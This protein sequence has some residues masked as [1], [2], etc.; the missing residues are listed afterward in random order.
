MIHNGYHTKGWARL[1]A[2][3]LAAGLLCACS[4]RPSSSQAPATVP[5]AAVQPTQVA[6]TEPETVADMV[7]MNGGANFLP[8][9]SLRLM[10]DTA[11]V[12]LTIAQTFHITRPEQALTTS[13]D[14]YFITGTS[15]P[16]KP[17]YFGTEEIV[18]QGT[19]GTFGV[20]VPLEMGENS[21]RFSQGGQ[22]TVV[23]ITRKSSTVSAIQVVQQDSMFPASQGG[24]KV[25][26]TLPVR[27]IAPAG[28]AVT[29]SFGGKTVT[30][31]QVAQANPGIP[32]VF[33]ADLTVSGDYPAGVTQKVG[34]VTYTLQYGG[35]T[36]TYK[37]TGDVYVAGANSSLAVRVKNYAGFVY[38]DLK[39][40]SNMKE[41][42]KKGAV[43][44]AA[45]EDSQYFKL[46]SGGWIPA[47]H[48]EIVTGEVKVANTLSGAGQSVTTKGE[49]YTFAGNRRPAYY[50][51]LSDGVFYLSLYNTTGVPKQNVSAS[52]L[53]SSVKVE[54]KEKYVVYAFTLKENASI[55]G[56][57]VTF[58]EDGLTLTFNYKPALSANSAQ[59]FKNVRILLDPGHGGTDPGALGVAGL[60]GPTEREVNMAHAYAIRDK[61]VAL[62]A[63]VKIAH[64]NDRYFSL[65]ERYIAI[66]EWDADIFLSI[67]HNSV[68]ENADA[69]KISGMEMYYHTVYSKKLA[70][71]MMKGLAGTL[72]RKERAVARSY[73]RVTL[74]PYAPAILMELGFM[75]NPL[76]YEKAANQNQI[77]L[78]ADGVV[79]GLKSCLA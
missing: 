56:Y 54:Q 12:N 3:V 59:P 52:R 73:Y 32:A 55:W 40:L 51:R 72:G 33:K 22:E 8:D 68:G 29:A 53:F 75:S 14:A 79:A 21:F 66:E 39:D 31:T 6:V 47:E 61:L 57:N 70:D 11:N 62:G 64:K 74:M 41:K 1:T 71:S 27:C 63:T 30:L 50:S 36:K 16:G 5:V 34:P 77:N 4:A 35:A 65:D 46:A 76:E 18:R 2:T 10:A 7:F 20:L 26:G 38:A 28:A 23:K 69:N 58:G 45:M 37:S 78:V 67:H 24:V 15:D 49:A 44:Y 19:K 43:D 48:V 9:T 13:L 60:Y 42:L 17:V 25:G